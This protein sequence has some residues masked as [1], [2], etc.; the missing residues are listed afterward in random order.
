ME[1]FS[2]MTERSASCAT[3]AGVRL[4]LKNL[5]VVEL[6]VAPQ[7]AGCC[8]THCLCT[9]GSKTKKRVS[10]VHVR[11]NDLLA[12]VAR[13]QFGRAVRWHRILLLILCLL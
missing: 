8:S 12:Y 13:G 9:V 2:A 11:A 4:C 7:L 1:C 3:C 6:G 5:V 10:S